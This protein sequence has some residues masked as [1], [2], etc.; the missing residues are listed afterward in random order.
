MIT[1]P[2]SSSCRSA[3]RQVTLAETNTDSHRFRI[4]VIG[5]N[6]IK[7]DGWRGTTFHTKIDS[8]EFAPVP[9]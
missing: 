3:A 4:E 1:R 9:R 5:G 6:Q 2:R 7:A 8:L